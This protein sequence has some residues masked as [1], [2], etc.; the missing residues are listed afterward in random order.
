MANFLPVISTVAKRNGEISSN[1]AKI[2]K[3][4]LFLKKI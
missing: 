2:Q 1:F 3:K 4:Y